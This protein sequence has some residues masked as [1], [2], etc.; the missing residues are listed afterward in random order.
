MDPP[1]RPL[2]K[3]ENLSVSYFSAAGPVRAVREFSLEVERGE[4]VALVGETGSGKSTVALA[5][6]NLL[7]NTGRAE[8]GE[9]HFA[10]M[11]LS[12][13]GPRSWRLARGKEI[14]MVFQDARGALNP[15]LTIG[16]QVAQALRAHQRLGRKAAREA[17]AAWLAAAGIP[18]PR[19]YMRRY[20]MELSGGMCQRVAI[21]IAVCN[22]PRLLIADEP[23]CALDPSIQAQILELLQGMKDRYGLAMILISH[24]LAMI[25]EF[26][27]RVAVMYH[28]RLIELGKT[29]DVFRNPAHPYT[30][31]LIECQAS[32]RHSWNLRPLA[33]IAGSPP[34][35]GQELT[36]CPFAP[37]C[38]K[39]DSDCLLQTPRP[40]TVSD[41]HWASCIRLTP[42]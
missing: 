34:A 40:V 25:S 36:G 30:A 33:A 9:I 6:L 39:A 15:V 21:A 19:F 29:E 37:R 7:G 14:G 32:L 23:T 1:T 38:H 5:M 18:Q 42:D 28:G 41:G 12:S 20:P 3:I 35:A 24:D 22:L 26:A 31:S 17:A 2:L 4:S 11:P 8:T 27:E 13:R 16:A 10:G